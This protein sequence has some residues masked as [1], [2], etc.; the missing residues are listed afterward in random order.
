[1]KKVNE[2]IK[3][4]LDSELEQ[5]HFSKQQEVV[6]R[7]YPITWKQKLNK[8]WNKEITIP[9]IPISAAFVMF[10]MVIGY[11]EINPL[12]LINH[13]R[14]EKKLID[15]GGNYYWKDDFERA[16]LKHEN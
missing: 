6:Q 4:R 11:V 15:V 13:E 7:I 2:Q 1:M 8:L 16:M 10:I 3:R 9:L 12:E 5:V 14:V